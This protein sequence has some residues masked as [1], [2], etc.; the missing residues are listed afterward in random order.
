MSLNALATPL[1]VF[2]IFFRQTDRQTDSQIQR[3][4]LTP[5]THVCGQLQLLRN[6]QLH[7][8]TI[9]HYINPT[10]TTGNNSPQP[11][12]GSVAVGTMY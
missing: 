12:S 4:C 3:H 11:F 10:L 2:S 1:E 7:V 5:A 9:T 8:I 6:V